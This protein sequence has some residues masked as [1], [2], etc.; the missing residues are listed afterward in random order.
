MR[1][2]GGWRLAA[3][4]AVVLGGALTLPFRDL[5]D[6]DETRRIERDSLF[7][8]AGFSL[9]E[10]WEVTGWPRMTIRRGEV[11]FQDGRVTA[12]PGSG[13]VLRRGPTQRI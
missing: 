9:F 3:V 13:Q 5:W 1:N 6:P 7:S 11:V 10:G 4:V 2:A 12:E 8:R